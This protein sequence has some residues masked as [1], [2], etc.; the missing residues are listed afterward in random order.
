MVSLLL[1]ELRS[2]LGGGSGCKCIVSPLGGGG[3]SSL[4]FEQANKGFAAVDFQH[5]SIILDFPWEG[6]GRGSAL[7]LQDYSCCGMNHPSA[8][9]G[10]L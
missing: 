10:W 9:F 3:L 4:N 6:G 7:L 5:L 1:I 8:S 2:Q